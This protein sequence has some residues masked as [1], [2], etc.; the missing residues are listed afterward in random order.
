M[1]YTVQAAARATGVSES[2]LRTWERRYGVPRPARST[3]GRRLYDEADLAVIRRMT[4]LIEAG[5]S[6]AQAA[7][8]AGSETD[9]AVV[10]IEQPMA[11]PHPAI[12]ELVGAAVGYDEHR[13]VGVIRRAF[14]ELGPAAAFERVLFPALFDIGRGWQRGE[15]SIANEHFA[16]ELIRRETLAA[17]AAAAAAAIG[18]PRVLLACV[19]GERH[20]LAIAALWLVLSE[21]S[22]MVLYLGADVPTPDLV[23]AAQ[24]A[25]PDVI[26]LSA[27][28]PTSL[29]ALAEA[30]RSLIRARVR[31]RVFFGGPALGYAPEDATAIP[32]GR[33]PVSLAQSSEVLV[34]TASAATTR[35]VS[36][37]PLAPVKR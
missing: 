25:D 11:A 16:S 13:A 33:L 34:A 22:C 7:E 4:A 12:A 6:A 27:T 8:A 21:A 5:L 28:A 15:L 37:P 26:A 36:T 20:D 29:P 14:D 10:A 32:G 1:H 9:G 2:R 18:A 17:V 24:W 35:P 19:A 30:G 3:S 23:S 31:G